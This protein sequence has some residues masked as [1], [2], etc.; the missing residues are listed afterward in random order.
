MR[1]QLFVYPALAAMLAV[2]PA[3]ALGMGFGNAAPVVDS[4]AISPS[5]VPA[6]GTATISCAAHDD[7]SV[8]RLTVSVSGGTL[9]GNTTSLDL[10]IVAGPSVS[11]TVAWSTPAPGSYTVT[12]TATDGGGSFGAPLS[13]PQSIVATVVAAGPPPVVDGVTASDTQVFPSDVVQLVGT[14]HDPTG[15]A[16]TYEWSAT[17]GTIVPSGT[18]ASWTATAAGSYSVTFTAVNA[19]GRDSESVAIQVVWARSAGTSIVDTAPQFV[20]ERVAIDAA[21]FAYVT[22]SRMGTVQVLTPLGEPLRAIPAGGRVSGVALASGGLWVSD[23]DLGAVKLIDGGGRVVGV[24]GS[25]VGE[26]ERPLDVAVNPANGTVYVADGEEEEVRIFSAAGAPLGTLAVT[27]GHPTGVAADPATGRVYVSDGGNGV[28][29][30]YDAGGVEVGTIGS[31]GSGDGQITRAAGV[32]LAPDGNLY[33]VDAYQGRVAVFSRTGAFLA[34]VGTYGSAPGQLWVPLGIASDSYGRLLVTNTM[35]ARV[36]V[37]ALRGASLPVCSTSD[38]DCDGMPNDWELRHGLNPN[39]PRDAY[40]DSDG[41]G[42]LNVDEWRHGTDPRNA[43]T[44][45]D[46][47]SDGDEVAA[48]FNPLDPDDHRPVFTASAPAESGPG[49]VRISSSVRDES[50]CSVSWRQVAGPSVSLRGTAAPSYVARRAADY[51]FEGIASCGSTSSQPVT[52]ST[53]ILD[54]APR[55]DPGRI[56]VLER[57]EDLRLDGRFTRDANGD[58][59]IGLGWDQTFG[60]AVSGPVAGATLSLEMETAGYYAFQLTAMDPAG[61]WSAAEAPVFVL[62]DDG[63]APTAL[64]A[65]P[66]A[67]EVGRGVSLDG[68]ASAGARSGALSFAWT[69]VSGPPIELAGADSARASF[70]PTAAGP[71]AFELSVQ[72]RGLRSPPARVDAYV[73][74]AGGSLP[75]AAVAAVQGPVAAGGPVS[76]DGSASASNSS[77]ALEYAWRQVS[78]PAAGLTDADR[79]IATVVPFEAGSYVFELTVTEGAAAGVPAR[80]RFDADQHGVVRPVAVASGPASVHANQ[81]ARLDGRGSS[82]GGRPINYRW[83]QVAGPWVALDTGDPARPRFRARLP[84]AYAFE[85]E[86]DDGAVRS[87]PAR[88]SVDVLPSE[89]QE[90][91]R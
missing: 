86:V 16:L 31:F 66:V 29:R 32:T 78:G 42:L 26:F 41:D 90:D 82:A 43:D 1:T 33:V 3:A 46:G 14:A 64:A 69:Q 50:A 34:F 52:V 73:A 88:V 75:T 6:N 76:L 28:V 9:P 65:S 84:G 91:E 72:Q 5:P 48:G 68:S 51:S 47:Y 83:T 25:G 18:S 23:L 62:G 53:A 80:V 40:V 38:S 27:G 12:C 20:P 71:Y 37:F 44:D 85:L 74:D 55:P 63:R 8:V 59:P 15:G 39:D 19:N 45:G 81:P 54:V 36:E 30:V 35:M 70:V 56:V 11:G 13:T 7:S 21:G 22:N 10:S 79:P 24:L 4:L 67:G 60:S 89:E 49:L 58:S 61:N 77:R 87:A 17:G 57:G 2:A